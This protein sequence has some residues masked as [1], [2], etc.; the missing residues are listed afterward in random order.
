MRAQRNPK[1]LVQRELTTNNMTGPT[2]S[3]TEDGALEGMMDAFVETPGEKS[4]ESNQNRKL[5]DE[6]MR[7]S[8][9]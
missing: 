5:I 4:P 6:W 7:S 8:T 3:E 9:T 1:R 2:K